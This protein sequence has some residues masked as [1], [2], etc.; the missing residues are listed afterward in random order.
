MRLISSSQR[1]WGTSRPSIPGVSPALY[2]SFLRLSAGRYRNI[3]T[4]Q[5]MVTGHCGTMAH[6]T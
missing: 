3:S 2:S 6:R 5:R 1:E 4:H